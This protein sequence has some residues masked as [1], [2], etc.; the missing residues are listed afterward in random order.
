MHRSNLNFYPGRTIEISNCDLCHLRSVCLLPNDT[1]VQYLRL[2]INFPCIVKT[3]AEDMNFDLDCTFSIISRGFRNGRAASESLF[4]LFV[5]F[6]TLSHFLSFFRHFC[7]FLL[8]KSAYCCCFSRNS[9]LRVP[10]LF[11]MLFI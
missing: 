5:T 7:H 4:S 6:K 10:N 9:L 11:F 8:Q 1:D 3:H 2:E